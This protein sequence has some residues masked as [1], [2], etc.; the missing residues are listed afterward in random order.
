TPRRFMSWPGEAERQGYAFA[1]GRKAAVPPPSPPRQG[2]FHQ[3]FQ[4]RRSFHGAEDSRL[5]GLRVTLLFHRG[6]SAE[7]SRPGTRCRRGVDALRT[8][9]RATADA[10]AGRGIS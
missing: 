5:L 2:L 8:R 4:G 3:A 7:G 10:A 6:G 9:T 1:Y